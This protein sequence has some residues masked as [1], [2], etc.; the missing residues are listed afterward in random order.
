MK[1]IVIIFLLLFSKSLFPQQ[2]SLKID[3]NHFIGKKTKHIIRA[4]EKE[5][6]YVI[7]MTPHIGC[8]FKAVGAWIYFSDSTTKLLVYFKRSFSRKTHI[9]NRKIYQSR[10]R[11]IK[12]FNKKTS[13]YFEDVNGY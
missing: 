7:Q 1:V 12:F 4:F 10:I 6:L 5:N 3:F 2:D 9:I 8:D 13:Y 11:S